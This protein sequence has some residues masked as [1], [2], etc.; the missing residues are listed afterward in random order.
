MKVLVAVDDSPCSQAALEFV[1][2]THWSKDT[3]FVVL[4]AV[5]VLASIYSLVEAGGY[6]VFPPMQEGQRKAAQELAARAERGLRDEGLVTEAKVELGDPREVI[7]RVAEEQGMNL[8][9]MGSHGRSGLR[10]LLMGSV[11]SHVTTHA[12]CS[13]LVVKLGRGMDPA[14]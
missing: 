14:A 6:T 9:V 10:K 7:L 13:V 1:R 4:S 5:P 8:I 12:R 2:R 11:A 3:K